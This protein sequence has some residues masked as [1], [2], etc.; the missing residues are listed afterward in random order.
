MG[1]PAAPLEGDVEPGEVPGGIVIAAVVEPRRDNRQREQA[2]A[3]F[4]L[5]RERDLQRTLSLANRDRVAVL[6]DSG[7]RQ[8]AAQRAPELRGA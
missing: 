1:L 3:A 5:G 7:L 2:D 8:R 6:D 4:A